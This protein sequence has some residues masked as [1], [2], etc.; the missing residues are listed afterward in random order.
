MSNEVDLNQDPADFAASFKSAQDPAD[1]SGQP[2]DP[3]P[4]GSKPAEE[5]TP[6][7]TPETPGEPAKPDQPDPQKPADPT[8]P[9][10][11]GVDPEEKPSTE[12]QPADPSGQPK[13]ETPEEKQAREAA[14]KIRELGEAKAQ[15]FKTMVSVV[16]NDPDAIKSI[17][18]EDPALADSIA[19]EVWG[20]DDY[21]DLMKQAEIDELRKEDPDK[22]AQQEQIYKLTKSNEKTQKQLRDKDENSFLQSKGIDKNPFDEKYKLL[23]QTLK[24][25][26]NSQLVEDNYA[27]ALNVAYALAFPSRT[28]E[29][30]EAD[31]KAILLAKGTGSQPA[32]KGIAPSSPATPASDFAPEQT[33]FAKMVGVNL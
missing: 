31:K 17:H 32:N 13:V 19:K 30:V 27:E 8:E 28:D 6:P 16:R 22:A 21:N 24:E 15:Q 14:N 7:E 26:V 33:G 5:P 9:A 10:K 2:K 18:S 3:E 11:P 29:Q 12:E 25:K 20:A 1:P 23:Q 4:A